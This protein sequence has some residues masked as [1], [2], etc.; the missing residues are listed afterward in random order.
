VDEF[1]N[2]DISRLDDFF[3]ENPQYDF[4]VLLDD[5]FEVTTLYGFESAPWNLL[6]DKTG[7]IRHRE[8]SLEEDQLRTWVEELI[9]E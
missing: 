4:P 2:L 8:Q 6:I 7:V 9:S 1:G 5:N 3:E